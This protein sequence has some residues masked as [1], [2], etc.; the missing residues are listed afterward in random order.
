LATVVSPLEYKKEDPATVQR[1][2]GLVSH[3][4]KRERSSQVRRPEEKALRH[5]LP[6]ST[7]S[8]ILIIKRSDKLDVGFYARSP[9][10]A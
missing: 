9:L 3:K 5:R 4:E 6:V 1:I 7:P 2:E 8:Y 10:T